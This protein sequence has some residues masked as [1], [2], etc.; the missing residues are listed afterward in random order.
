M[1]YEQATKVN[2]TR[3]SA[4]CCGHCK[5]GEYLHGEID[6]PLNCKKF[7]MHTNPN[8][9]CDDFEKKDQ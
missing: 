8:A 4:E 5:F 6:W 1:K 3:R 7:D 9:V 2:P